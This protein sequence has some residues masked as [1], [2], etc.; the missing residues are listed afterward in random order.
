MESLKHVNGVRARVPSAKRLLAALAT[1]APL[2]LAG[3]TGVSAAPMPSGFN[4]VPPSTTTN[5]FAFAP[6]QTYSPSS[7][8][9]SILATGLAVHDVNGDNRPDMVT[10][11]RNDSSVSVIPNGGVGSFAG[12]YAVGTHALTAAVHD[13]N[14][15]GYPDIVT[16]DTDVSTVS[17]LLNDGTSSPGNFVASVAYSTG[18]KPVDVAIEDV[19]N[20]GSPDI[21][22]ANNQG[23]N[24]S[25]LLNNGD[26]TFG[27]PT[28]Y[29]VGSTPNG[30]VVADFNGD[31]QPDIA[32]TNFGTSSQTSNTVSVLYADGNGGFAAQ[33]TFD[34]G[35]RP[36]HI[37][38]GDLNG[39]GFPDLVV[40]DWGSIRNS[41]NNL[42]VLLNNGQTGADAGFDAPL[43]VSLPDQNTFSSNPTPAVA[44][45][46]GDG[47]QDVVVANGPQ[48]YV[49]PGQGDGSFA[50]PPA[51][52]AT[53]GN[54]LPV[55][56]ADMNG[57]G[58]PDVIA[59]E[60]SGLVSV[61][62]HEFAPTETSRPTLHGPA[63]VGHALTGFLGGWNSM[64]PPTLTWTMLRCDASAQNCTTTVGTGTWPLFYYPTPG[65]V[66]STLRVAV[67]ASN[68]AGYS[69]TVYSLASK[70]VPAPPANTAPPRSP[71]TLPTGTRSPLAVTSGTRRCTGPT[72]GGSVIPETRT[73]PITSTTASRWLSARP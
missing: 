8:D 66:G 29:A 72:G 57:D 12:T 56:V 41:T 48:A 28:N 26:G 34:A 61:N 71:A 27:S 4:T 33:Q 60:D 45:L 15:D 64:V 2:A 49:Y 67:V 44:D 42:S 52:V 5:P 30:L 51:G 14:G 23:D 70:V 17:V 21:I 62:L 73:P 7:S 31:G 39:D 22:T 20:D 43:Q 1:A 35:D 32:T 40:T 53:G 25:V 68:D 50:S 38:F 37:A 47:F 9:P 63:L 19:N 69:G 6:A 18:L 59:V 46:N 13:L 10:V 16:A 11:N 54:T 24:V 36:Y 3:V 55:A 58:A 65:D